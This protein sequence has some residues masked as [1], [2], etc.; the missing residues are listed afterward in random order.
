MATDDDF[1]E[2]L[3]QYLVL[4][5]LIGIIFVAVTFYYDYLATRRSRE[6]ENRSEQILLA[7]ETYMNVVSDMENLFSMM[8]YSAWNVV[9]RKARP[10]GIFSDDLMD[11]DENKYVKRQL[12]TQHGKTPDTIAFSCKDGTCLMIH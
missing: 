3:L 10:S 7:R 12:R 9:W 2:P 1:L 5:F 11:E 6:K 4:P 8:K